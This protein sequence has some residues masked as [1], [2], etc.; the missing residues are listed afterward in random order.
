MGAAW[1][2]AAK[3]ALL[4]RVTNEQREYENAREHPVPA[5]SRKDFVRRPMV[6]SIEWLTVRTLLFGPN[7]PDLHGATAALLSAPLR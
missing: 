5:G 2:Y 7:S 6:V 1:L 3:S 4:D